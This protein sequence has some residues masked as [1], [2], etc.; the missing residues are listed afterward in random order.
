M[1][2]FL[3]IILP[4]VQQIVITFGRNVY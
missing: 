3:A 1:A 4:N 2:L